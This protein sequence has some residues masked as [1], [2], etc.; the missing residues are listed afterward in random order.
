MRRAE[1]P[2]GG[3]RPLPIPAALWTCV[4]SSASSKLG[5]GSIPGRRRA[6]I[7]LPAPGGPDHQQVVAAGGGD[8][9]RPLGVVLAADVGQVGALGC[10][11]RPR[12]RAPA[13]APAASARAAGPRSAPATGC[14]APRCPRRA[15]P[16]GR[17]PPAPAGC[18]S[19]S[20]ARPS[21]T[22]SAPRTGRSSPVSDSSPQTA[23]PPSGSCGTCS[24]AAST[25]TAI[26]RSKL[27]PSLR[28]CAGARFTVI[29]FCGN[30]SPELSSAARTRSRDSRIARSGQADEREREQPAAHVDLHRHLVAGDP[31]EGERG[32][33]GEHGG[34]RYG[35]PR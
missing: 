11:G 31:F 1:G 7:V 10:R 30:S 2:L 4:T 35:A 15:P 16:R 3:E 13:R 23:Q 29:R 32:D 12:L 34:G 9:E 33:A 21:A 14:R 20:G 26:A 19:R 17:W 25:P 8:L 27:G 5:G 24:L 22:A 18:G 6:S 28:T